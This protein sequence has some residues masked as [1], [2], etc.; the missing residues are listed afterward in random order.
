MKTRAGRVFTRC[1]VRCAAKATTYRDI[2][3]GNIVATDPMNFLET[4]GPLF[5]NWTENIQQW[6]LNNMTSGGSGS[7]SL[8]E[9][10]AKAF[11]EGTSI[12]FYFDNIVQST[13][14]P[15][16]DDITVR[17]MWF[18]LP[19]RQSYAITDTA[20]RT[21]LRWSSTDPTTGAAYSASATKL[22]AG[23]QF[24]TVANIG[25]WNYITGATT[26]KTVVMYP[27]FKKFVLRSKAVVNTD[28]TGDRPGAR[29]KHF[30]ISWKPRRP[31]T[32]ST[33]FNTDSDTFTFADQTKGLTR[34][35]MVCA[36]NYCIEPSGT[37][38]HCRFRSE[39]CTTGRSLA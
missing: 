25:D 1:A 29:S 14:I 7:G 26:N 3:Y 38:D 31:M 21:R 10:E 17:V 35:I 28:I 23:N 6:I 32:F 9:N 15:N 2:I 19:N 20:G 5:L 18:Y 33:E 24:D 4:N 12:K 30:K 13:G 39:F 27:K 34:Y 16:G 37:D 8:P 36:D 22:W 11:M